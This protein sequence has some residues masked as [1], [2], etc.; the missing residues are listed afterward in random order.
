[1]RNLTVVD[2]PH[3]HDFYNLIYIKRGSGTHDIDFKRFDVEPNQ[4]FFMND[5]QVH[6][7]NLSDDTIGYTLFFKKE[8]FEVVEKSLSLQALPF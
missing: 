7:W 8:F 5:S 3:R 1:M 2:F 6:E 4:I